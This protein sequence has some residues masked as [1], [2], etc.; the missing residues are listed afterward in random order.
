MIYNKIEEF[1]LNE[2]E[3]YIVAKLYEHMTQQELRDFHLTDNEI[4]IFENLYRDF[5]R[6]KR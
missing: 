5:C 1:I 3:M 2:E 4:D 6:I